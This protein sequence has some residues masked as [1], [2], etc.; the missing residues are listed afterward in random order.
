MLCGLTKDPK[1][2][3]ESI[4]DGTYTYH[5]AISK[6]LVRDTTTRKREDIPE[7]AMLVQNKSR[8]FFSCGKLGLLSR[9]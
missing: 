3:D 1:I 8:K 5:G 2:T 9:S 6:L 7:T 4:I